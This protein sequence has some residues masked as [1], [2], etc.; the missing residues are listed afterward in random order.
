[1]TFFIDVNLL[2]ILTL[3][4]L[5][6]ITKSNLFFEKF[7][8]FRWSICG[9]IHLISINFAVGILSVSV[10]VLPLLHL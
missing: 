5:A 10:T 4:F 1:M 9:E 3:K 8:Y 6:D 2:H 7:S